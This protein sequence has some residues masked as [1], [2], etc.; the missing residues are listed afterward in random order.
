MS[1]IDII[2][3]GKSSPWHSGWKGWT[4]SVDVFFGKKQ[5]GRLVAT[6]SRRDLLDY[7]FVSNHPA[8]KNYP[9]IGVIGINS[10]KKAVRKA[11][12][13]VEA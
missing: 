5:M 6:G 13:K 1:L 2:R 8:E 12:G 4:N 9:R 10:A 3:F 7:H 11:F